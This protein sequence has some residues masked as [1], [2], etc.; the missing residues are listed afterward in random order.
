M[1][2]FEKYTIYCGFM[3]PPILYIVLWAVFGKA[4]IFPDTMVLYHCQMANT[5]DG[6]RKRNRIQ[7]QREF[8]PFHHMKGIHIVLYS[9]HH[10]T[11]QF[12]PFD[13]Q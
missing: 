10:I 11:L 9:V 8:C 2:K 6:T 4:C 12:Y 5:P 1:G 13:V 7:V 3:Y